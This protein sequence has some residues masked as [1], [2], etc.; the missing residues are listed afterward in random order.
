[1]FLIGRNGTE[2]VLPELMATISDLYK[3]F[4]TER[5]TLTENSIKKLD[6]FM[7]Q[8]RAEQSAKVVPLIENTLTVPTGEQT[9]AADQTGSSDTP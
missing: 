3:E 7:A 5:N 8:K 9:S 6:N 4:V 2:R 1:M